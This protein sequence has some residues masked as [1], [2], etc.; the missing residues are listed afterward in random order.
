MEK[1]SEDSAVDGRSSDGQAL[2]MRKDE[3]G[4]CSLKKDRMRLVENGEGE[5]VVK[6]EATKR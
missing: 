6:C 4:D 2:Y 3:P 5:K 1:S